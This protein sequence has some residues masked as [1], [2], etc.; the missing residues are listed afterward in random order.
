MYRVDR[1]GALEQARAA[2]ARWRA[3]QPLSRAR[4]RAGDHQGEHRTR[5]ATRRRSARAPTR[6]PP[7]QAA[8]APPAAR[9]RE[10]GCVIL[11]KTTMPDY[12][13]LSSGP[14]EPARRD[15]QSLAPA[16]A[17]PRARAPAPAPRP[18]PATRR[19]T[20]APTSAARCACRRRIAASS[21]SSP[22]LG[23]VPVYPPYMGRVAGPMTRDG[24]RRGADDERAVEARCARLHEPARIEQIDFAAASTASNPKRLRIGFLPTCS[25][26]L[27][28][29]PEVRAARR[30]RRTRSR[31]AGAEAS[32]RCRASSRR[33]C[34]T[35]C[36]A[37]SRRA[38][39]TISCS[40]RRSGRRRCCRS[41]PSGA[42]GARR[43][44]A[45]AT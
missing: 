22:A 15:A 17:T 1:E 16:S 18:P 26:G 33:R 43:I 35:A 2:E 45:A 31:G 27:P 11:G 29:Q 20:S 36:A 5:A 21:R 6:T 14:V 25:V 40:C 3:R 28:V 10:A 41:S 42:P 30:R 8:D 19:C 32:R 37:S 13:M 38:R 24:R 23:R 34:S 39:T 7:P 4:R 12:G 9:L 44:S